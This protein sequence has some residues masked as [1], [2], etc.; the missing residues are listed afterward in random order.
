MFSHIGVNAAFNA[1]LTTLNVAY[2]R[3][4]LANAQRSTFAA[5]RRVSRDESV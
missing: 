2:H 3:L 4:T 1:A 5:R